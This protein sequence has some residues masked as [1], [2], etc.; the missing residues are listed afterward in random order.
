MQALQ[1]LMKNVF[2][3]T[4]HRPLAGMITESNGDSLINH[5][6]RPDRKRHQYNSLADS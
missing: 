6:H 3:G 5:L 2:L 1:E 4:V